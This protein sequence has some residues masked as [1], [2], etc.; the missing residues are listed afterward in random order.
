[1]QKAVTQNQG[2]TVEPLLD[3]RDIARILKRSVS[4]IRRDRLMRKGVPAILIGSSVRYTPESLRAF[5]R[6]CE[7]QS[8]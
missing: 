4:S 2:S 1:M 8:I 7:E 3:E 5:L 6:S